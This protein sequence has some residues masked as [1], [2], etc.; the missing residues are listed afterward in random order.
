LFKPLNDRF[1]H[2]AGDTTLQRIAHNLAANLAP[3][4]LAARLG[5]DE[6][7]ILLSGVLAAETLAVTDRIRRALELEIDVQS[8]PA[9]SVT[10][11]AGAVALTP[12]AAAQPREVL[13]AA[14]RALR[15]AKQQGRDQTV[16]ENVV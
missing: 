8:P 16:V 9:A 10:V 5:G 1:G 2:I 11:S 7:G 4:H 13:I 15:L 14:D 6:F 12:L 3:P